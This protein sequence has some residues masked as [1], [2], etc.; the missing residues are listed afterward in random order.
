MLLTMEIF[1]VHWE[2]MECLL[3]ETSVHSDVYIL[4][5]STA[6]KCW[7][8]RGKSGWTGDQTECIEGN[9]VIGICLIFI[10]KP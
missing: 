10:P 7:V 3:V 2:V 6:R 1:T 5:G 8:W 9:K 4:G